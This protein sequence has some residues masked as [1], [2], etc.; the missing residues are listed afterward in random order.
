[1]AFRPSLGDIGFDHLS[2]RVSVR[3][4]ERTVCLGHLAPLVSMLCKDNAKKEKFFGTPDIASG[5]LNPSPWDDA[6]AISSM[7]S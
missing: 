5:H 7:L 4:G 1:M 2:K 3:S 6:N